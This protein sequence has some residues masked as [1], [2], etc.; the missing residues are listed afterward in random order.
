M[1]RAAS[2]IPTCCVLELR[3]WISRQRPPILKAFQQVVDNGHFGYPYK[4]EDYYQAV[5]GYFKRHCQF[6]I[7]KEWIANS[8]AIYPSFQSLIE[9]LSDPGDEVK[10]AI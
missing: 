1:S 10:H 6:E 7:K 8:V 2:A 4:R 9:G 5:I 3:R